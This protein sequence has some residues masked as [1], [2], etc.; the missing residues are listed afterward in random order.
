M[1]VGQNGPC[2]SVRGP[3]TMVLRI[4]LAHVPILLLSMKAETVLELPGKTS[5]VYL[6]VVKVSSH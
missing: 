3:V 5:V 1:V 2:R 4:G 6:L